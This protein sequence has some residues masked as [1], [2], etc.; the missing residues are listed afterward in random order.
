MQIDREKERS[1]F[2]LFP[3]SLSSSGHGHL[4]VIQSTASS[5]SP[6][7]LSWESQV[8]REPRDSNDSSKG[9]TGPHHR[10]VVPAHP[11]SWAHLLQ[12]GSQVLQSGAH[13]SPR[14][15]SSYTPSHLRVPTP[16]PMHSLQYCQ[17]GFYTAYPLC[18][19]CPSF[20]TASLPVSLP[21][22]WA[23]RPSMW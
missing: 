7:C 15:I 19:K 10:L 2:P 12:P 21:T 22:S 9:H 17:V 23:G 5:L 11:T 3:L 6:R 13:L 20:L 16:R 8:C 18:P 1:L 14:L 4:S